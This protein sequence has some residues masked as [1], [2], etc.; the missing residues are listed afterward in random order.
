MKY[1]KEWKDRRNK[2]LNFAADV[3]DGMD[4]KK[5]VV[6]EMFGLETDEEAGIT[7]IPDMINIPSGSSNHGIRKPLAILGNI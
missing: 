1:L 4:K 6:V 5:S 7:R 3:A 2:A